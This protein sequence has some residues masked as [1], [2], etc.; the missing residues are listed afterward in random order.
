MVHLPRCDQAPGL[1]E[2]VRRAFAPYLALG[3]ESLVELP[4]TQMLNHVPV[5]LDPP[6]PGCVWS[7]RLTSV[8]CWELRDGAGRVVARAATAPESD[9][10]VPRE[11]VTKYPHS[12]HQ[13][14][15]GAGPGFLDENPHSYDLKRLRDGPFFNGYIVGDELVGCLNVGHAARFFLFMAQFP[16]LAVADDEGYWDGEALLARLDFTSP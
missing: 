2:W 8:A 3:D 1:E 6:Q 10:R 12:Y 5:L 15:I 7:G 4:L 9:P 14:A 11:I 13:T 16:G